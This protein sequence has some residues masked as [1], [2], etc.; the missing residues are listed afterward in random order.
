MKGIDMA[1]QNVSVPR[2]APADDVSGEEAQVA[3]V[4]NSRRVRAELF[5]ENL[6][7]D[8]AWDMLLELYANEL[9][10]RCSSI[11]GISDVAGVPLTTAARWMAALED[12]NLVAR[13]NDQ[14]D[15]R[16]VWIRLTSHGVSLMHRYFVRGTHAVRP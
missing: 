6:F 15:G 7:A 11:S 16:R 9:R 14:L 1:L 5:G 4:Q 8:P 3:L 2:S 10:Q 12:R 13:A